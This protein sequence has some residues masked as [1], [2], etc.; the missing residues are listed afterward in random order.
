MAI[1]RSTFELRFTS[2]EGEEKRHEEM[3]HQHDYRR[4]RPSRRTARYDR[5]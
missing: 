5:S 2:L 4:R 1:F 3:E